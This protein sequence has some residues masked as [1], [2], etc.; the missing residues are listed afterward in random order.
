MVAD[1]VKLSDGDCSIKAS[2]LYHRWKCNFFE[3]RF[4]VKVTHLVLKVHKDKM[5]VILV[6]LVYR[7][8]FEE[9]WLCLEQGAK[10]FRLRRMKNGPEKHAASDFKAVIGGFDVLESCRC[11][12]AAGNKNE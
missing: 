2:L 8:V 5:I 9:L 6:M 4:S 12:D 1:C 7:A 10:D 11:A 3:A